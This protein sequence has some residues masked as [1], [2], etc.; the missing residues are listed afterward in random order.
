MT[1][2]IYLQLLRWVGRIGREQ[3]EHVDETT[4]CPRAHACIFVL[5]QTRVRQFCRDG[6]ERLAMCLLLVYCPQLVQQCLQPRHQLAHADLLAWPPHQRLL[7]LQWLDSILLLF[8]FLL[9]F[10]F[11]LLDNFYCRC[12]AAPA[13]WSHVACWRVQ[14]AYIMPLWVW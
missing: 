8:F 4:A 5:Q 6:L 11:H 3:L 14:C 13:A 7:E 9:H 1:A 2:R 10:W 12:S